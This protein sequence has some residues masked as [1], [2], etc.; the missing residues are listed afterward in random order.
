MSRQ[1]RRA[2][3]KRIAEERGGSNMDK[4]DLD[5]LYDLLMRYLDYT[6]GEKVLDAVVMVT[7]DIERF[8]R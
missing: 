4:K 2:E 3:L 6:A 1:E 8:Y 5:T 7:R